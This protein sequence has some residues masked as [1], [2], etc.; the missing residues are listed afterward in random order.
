[1]TV[2]R[3]LGMDL[4]P[5]A[6]SGRHREPASSVE[7][8]RLSATAAFWVD[9][10]SVDRWAAV[11]GRSMKPIAQA[12]QQ[13]RFVLTKTPSPPVEGSIRRWVEHQRDVVVAPEVDSAS[14]VFWRLAVRQ[15]AFAIDAYPSADVRIASDRVRRITLR[16]AH[17]EVRL[18]FFAGSSI[19]SWVVVDGGTPVMVGMPEYH[20]VLT[21]DPALSL[22]ALVAT[23]RIKPKVH[24]VT[25]ER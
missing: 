21:D 7:L 15:K 24:E 13:G 16:A 20:L 25:V 6:G 2:E 17:L 11:Y 19:P 9:A 18:G 3:L 4:H 5:A 22:G 1:M 14:L 8:P 10:G 12:G 23:A